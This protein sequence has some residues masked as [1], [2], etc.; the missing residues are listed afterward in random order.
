MNELQIFQKHFTEYGIVVFGGLD[1]EGV[2]FDGEIKFEEMINFHYDDVNRHY[3][4]ITNL[5][6]A[7]VKRYV[8]KGCNK[9]CRYDVMHKCQETCSD[10]MSICPCVYTYVRIPCGSCNITFRNQSCFHKHK[11]NKLKGKTVC[12]RK[13]NCANCG[14]LLTP[15]NK[16]KCF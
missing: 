16:H 15:R 10:C 8:C 14:S 1:C 5:T 6:G 12:E 11:T 2:I 7:I 4:V 3:H 13:R 9:G